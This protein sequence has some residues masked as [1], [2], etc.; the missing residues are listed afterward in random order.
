VRYD[1]YVIRH[2]RVKHVGGGPKSRSRGFAYP[3]SSV[4]QSVACRVSGDVLNDHH[5]NVKLTWPKVAYMCT[6]YG[7]Q[8]FINSQKARYFCVSLLCL[9]LHVLA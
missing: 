6:D 4:V 3:N 8:T 2:Q 9:I 5:D 7:N 1:I